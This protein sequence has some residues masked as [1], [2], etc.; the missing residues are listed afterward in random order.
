MEQYLGTIA[1]R[2][3][4]VLTSVLAA[5]L[6]I[7]GALV[8]AFPA[9]LGW[10]VGIGLLLAGVALIAVVLTGFQPTDA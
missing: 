6:L 7:L 3:G 8:I 9:L 2:L 1:I 5:L 10:V 4:P